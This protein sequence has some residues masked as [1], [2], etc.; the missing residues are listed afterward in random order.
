MDDDR[1]THDWEGA[2][3]LLDTPSS[4]HR[5][6][7]NAYGR[8]L[9]R[10]QD[11]VI[12]VM[13]QHPG[14]GCGLVRVGQADGFLT[15][16]NELRAIGAVDL[17]LIEAT[18][19]DI[20]QSMREGRRIPVALTRSRPRSDVAWPPPSCNTTSTSRA[21]SAP[22]STSPTPP[23]P[24]TT[25]TRPSVTGRCS[26][27]CWTRRRRGPA[28]ASNSTTSRAHW[29]SGPG[30]H[31]DTR[32]ETVAVGSLCKGTRPPEAPFAVCHAGRSGRVLCEGQPVTP[33]GHVFSGTT[34]APARGHS[35]E[36]I[37]NAEG[38]KPRKSGRGPVP[39]ARACSRGRRSGTHLARRNQAPATV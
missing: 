11:R 26:G 13:L 29:T 12:S 34:C 39:E 8:V 10:L 14:V 4:D 22:S 32:G 23:R 35:S 20:A 16:G 1:L 21:P 5:L 3:A 2:I 17:A 6:L 18:R 38:P 33:S 19:P 31:L 27:W 15:R 9:D 36:L 28:W 7:I 24:S 30:N 25:S 37:N